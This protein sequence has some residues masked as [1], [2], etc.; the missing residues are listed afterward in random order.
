MPFLL[1]RPVHYVVPFGQ[2]LQQ[3]R[4]LLG[5]M[6][7]IIVH[8]D[9]DLVPS[10]PDATQERVV[11][12]VIA[13]QA[14]APDPG[15]GFPELRND[16]PTRINAAVVYKY[17]LEPRGSSLQRHAQPLRE[18]PKNPSGV[19]HRHHDGHTHRI[20]HEDSLRTTIIPCTT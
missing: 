17:E 2:L 12:A 14:D 18:V 10:S 3:S 9:D 11:L 20:G 8:G 5:R 13:H 19:V 15:I 7:E 4:D 6:L 16:P 1:R